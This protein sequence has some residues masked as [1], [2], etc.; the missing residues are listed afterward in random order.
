MVAECWRVLRSRIQVVYGNPH[1]DATLLSGVS[2]RRQRAREKLLGLEDTVNK[3]LR[4]TLT[5]MSAMAGCRSGPK[6]RVMT[7]V[8]S[9]R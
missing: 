6:Q 7:P 4:W 5:A 3:A 1:D 9:C 8:Q 2:G